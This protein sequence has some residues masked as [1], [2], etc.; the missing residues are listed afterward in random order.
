MLKQLLKWLD[1]SLGHIK[2]VA[3]VND[4]R[5]RVLSIRLRGPG[6]P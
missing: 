6:H 1:T 3:S 2:L 5:R 4:G